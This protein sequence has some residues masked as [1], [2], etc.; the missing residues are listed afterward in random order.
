LKGDADL[1]D[2]FKQLVDSVSTSTNVKPDKH[3]ILV[4]VGRS[5]AGKASDEPSC[6]CIPFLVNLL[7]LTQTSAL[8][9]MPLSPMVSASAV[10]LEPADREDLKRPLGGFCFSDAGWA[11]APAR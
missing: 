8:A 10:L 6:T 1:A 3:R 2:A 5:G 9:P 4:I 11:P 7:L